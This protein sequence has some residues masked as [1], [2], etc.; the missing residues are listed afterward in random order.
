MTSKLTTSVFAMYFIFHA[1]ILNAYFFE[2]PATFNPVGQGAR[3]LALGGAYIGEG[4]EATGDSWN[5]ACLCLMRYS[6]IALMS[7][8]LYRKEDNFF[9][10]RHDLSNV[11]R[12]SEQDL[13]YIGAV[14]PFKGFKRNMVMSMSYQQVYSMDREWNF[15]NKVHVFDDLYTIDRWNYIQSGGLS[16]IGL[17][18]G[19]QINP[20]L[21]LGIKCNFWDNSLSENKWKQKYHSKGKVIS[22]ANE[23]SSEFHKTESFSFKGHNFNLGLLYKINYK[24]YIGAIIKTPFRATID[25]QMDSV[26]SLDSA[27]NKP[28]I[29]N[30]KATYHMDIPFSFGLGMIYN[31]SDQFRMSM[32]AYCT[33]WDKFKQTNE[34]G[35]EVFPITLKP[36]ES[37]DVDPTIQFRMGAEYLWQYKDYFIPIRGGLF[38]DP[39]P[40]D[41]QSNEFWGVTVGTGLTKNQKYSVDIAYQ[42]RY[43]NDI[44]TSD[45][46]HLGFSQDISEHSV[47]ISMNYYFAGQAWEY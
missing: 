40:G 19:I 17:T 4:S 44:N 18:Y 37:V 1:S 20:S 13:N 30:D 42:Y 15:V 14:I 7:S 26:T 11:G 12:I 9:S 3:G 41:N 5:P 2:L 38:Y 16:T 46:S 43:G 45:L 10:K 6:E 32:D 25:Y 36:I 33:R 24:F 35:E 22:G 28:D 21:Y 34:K 23:S 39:A 47:F 31:F 27:P 29:D 8:F